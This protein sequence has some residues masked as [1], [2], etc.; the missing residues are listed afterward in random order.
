[1]KAAKIAGLVVLG[2]W[3]VHITFRIEQIRHSSQMACVF[4]H[5]AAHS[6]TALDIIPECS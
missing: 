2:L 6:G 4:A 5:E 3:M 1:M